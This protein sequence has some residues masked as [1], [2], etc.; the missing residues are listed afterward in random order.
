MNN[1]L[2]VLGGKSNNL[3]VHSLGEK[4]V[5][6]FPEINKYL[7]A[8]SLVAEIVTALMDGK[9]DHSIQL[10]CCDRV[11]TNEEQ[12]SALIGEVRKTLFSLSDSAQNGANMAPATLSGFLDDKE[13]VRR[14]YRINDVVFFVEYET[15]RASEILHPKFSLFEIERVDEFD[16]S[17]K[18]FHQNHTFSLQADGREIGSWGEADDHFLGGK[19]SMEILQQLYGKEEH[20]WMGVFHA[21]GISDGEKC[22][23]FLGDSGSGKST[24]SALLMAGGLD[25][26][27]DDF[28]PVESKRKNVYRFPA[29]ISLKKGA[30]QALRSMFPELDHSAE[31]TNKEA[32]KTFRFLSQT[33][34][35]PGCVPCI[36]LVFVTYEPNAGVQLSRMP[37][38]VAFQQ[39]IPD[40]WISPSATN[41]KGFLQWFDDLP[42]WKLRYSDNDAM[43][44]TVKKMLNERG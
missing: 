21:S 8:D 18:V 37:K 30:V 28:L 14:Y 31:Y 20:E 25:V 17:L 6:W 32:N 40:S 4:K 36:A 27:S 3:L 26:L 24:L 35:E 22:M 16:H 33:N 7:L 39:L 2:S 19:F 9:D 15:S 10:A 11:E 38:E 29:A 12:V 13:V 5:I 41:V 42:C 23:M 1:F 43:V 44:K 34:T